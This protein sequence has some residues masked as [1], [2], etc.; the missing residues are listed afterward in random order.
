MNGHLYEADAVT[1][2]TFPYLTFYC[3]ETVFNGQLKVTTANTIQYMIN[4]L[5]HNML[6]PFSTRRICSREHKIQLR[7]WLTKKRTFSLTNHV[8][9]FGVRANKFA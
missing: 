5:F 1:F 2:L 9:E 7:D 6:S 3:F 8:G 4:Y